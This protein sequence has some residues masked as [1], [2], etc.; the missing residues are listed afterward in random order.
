MGIITEAVKKAVVVGDDSL[1]VCMTGENLVD[2]STLTYALNITEYESDRRD[3][4]IMKVH[5]KARLLYN[6]PL[7]MLNR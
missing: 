3:H 1:Y 2:P 7:T 4:I 6:V 5:M